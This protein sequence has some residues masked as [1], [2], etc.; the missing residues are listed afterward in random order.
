M[1]RLWVKIL[2]AAS[3]CLNAGFLG[4]LGVHVLQHRRSHD[5]SE[6]KLSPQAKADMDANFKAFRERLSPLSSDLRAERLRMLDVLA[7]ESPSPDAVAAQQA[8]ILAATERMLQATDDHLLVQKK[9]L[10]PEQQRLFFDHIRSRI[11][12]GDRRSPFP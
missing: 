1:R 8:K 7:S 9:L 2:L 10:T 6:L 11:Q 5:M 4:A 3:L 12:D